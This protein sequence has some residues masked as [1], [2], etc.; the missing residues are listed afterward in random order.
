MKTAHAMSIVKAVWEAGGAGQPARDG[1]AFFMFKRAEGRRYH[2]DFS[3]TERFDGLGLSF[4]CS[5]VPDPL[6]DAV[7]FI[8]QQPHR[9]FPKKSREWQF[10]QVHGTEL[11]AL[12]GRVMAEA[13]S[14]IRDTEFDSHLAWLASTLDVPGSH[15]L[16]HLAALASVGNQETLRNYLLRISDADRGGLF[17]YITSELLERALLHAQAVR[18][19][20]A[21]QAQ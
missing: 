6:G 9:V 20:G 14:W 21:I 16:W 5:F 11:Q 2:L 18:A 8:D 7:D 10:F 3:F 13:E 15:Q 17:P 12:A 4:G 1:R 19:S